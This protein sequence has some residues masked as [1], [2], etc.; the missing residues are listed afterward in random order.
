[1]SLGRDLLDLS[2]ETD[3]PPGP[4]LC[5]SAQAGA[6]LT[7]TQA[8]VLYCFHPQRFLGKRAHVSTLVPHGAAASPQPLIAGTD[9]RGT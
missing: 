6:A 5:R 3:W 2:L 8:D 7:G 1:M 4:T 9:A